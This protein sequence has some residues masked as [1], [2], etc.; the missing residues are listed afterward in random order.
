MIVHTTSIAGLHRVTFDRHVD[1]R[2]TFARVFDADVFA[3]AGLPVSYPHHGA[4]TN[5]FAGTVRG[6]HL[7]REPYGEAKLIRVTR[8]AIWD[9]VVDVRPDSPTCRAWEAFEVHADGVEMIAISPGLAH[10][11][12]TLSPDSDVHYLLSSRYE[13]D[14][15]TGI[16]PTDPQLNLPW[17]VPIT[18]IGARDRAL[19][20]LAFYEKRLQR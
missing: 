1:E 10:G 14:F 6:L 18:V 12:Q 15:A 8:G 13:P 3:A 9:V 17:P 4:A 5:L 20:N 11:Y 7:Q 2:G 19:P 16:N